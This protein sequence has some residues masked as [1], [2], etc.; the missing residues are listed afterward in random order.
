MF[1][2][3]SCFVEDH[4][5]LFSLSIAWCGFTPYEPNSPCFNLAYKNI[6]VSMKPMS[7]IKGIEFGRIQ[8]I[9][10]TVILAF[11][12]SAPPRPAPP[13]PFTYLSGWISAP[14]S[15]LLTQQRG[16]QS[17]KIFAKNCLRRPSV[18]QKKLQGWLLQCF[19]VHLPQEAYTT[20]MGALP[21][22]KIEMEME[23]PKQRM[24]FVDA[25]LDML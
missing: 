17:L 23:I 10:I 15:L 18:H 19:Q 24:S 3:L 14:C 8:R 13:S 20:S 4:C 25:C 5:A 22:S 9:I 12:S 6:P 2:T 7:T 21:W 16:Q 11:H 1:L